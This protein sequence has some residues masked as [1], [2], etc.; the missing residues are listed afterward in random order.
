MKRHE[1]MPCYTIA[2]AHCCRPAP[3][4]KGQVTIVNVPQGL[5]PLSAGT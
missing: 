5:L 2:R 3:G 4:H 1:E